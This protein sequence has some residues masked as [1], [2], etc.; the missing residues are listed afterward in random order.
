MRQDP[1][2]PQLPVQRGGGR[3][4][5]GAQ[6]DRIS[7]PAPWRQDGKRNRDARRGGAGQELL[8]GRVESDLQEYATVITQNE[9]E[10][11]FNTWASRKLFM[12]ANE[13][14]SRSEL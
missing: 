2:A 13:V 6:L 10:S 1:R 9:L 14:V 8:L 4:H 11:Q 5:V 7:A 3:L 12:V